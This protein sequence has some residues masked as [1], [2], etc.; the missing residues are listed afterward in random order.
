M[1][2][3]HEDCT[4]QNFSAVTGHIPLSQG[5][6]EALWSM[7]CKGGDHLNDGEKELLFHLLMEY[8]DVFAFNSGQIGRTSI[9]KHRIDTGNTPPVHL[10]PR[11]IHQAR[12]E[13]MA[14]LVKDMLEQG[15]IQ[16][17]DCPWS[18]PV[19]LVK[20]KNRSVRFCVDYRKVNSENAYPLPRVDDT[21]DTLAGSRLFTTLDLASGYWQ[22]EVAEDQPKTAFTTPEGLFQFRVM[23]F[24]LCNAP[25]T[26][27]RLMDRVLSELKWSSCLVYLDGIIIVGTSFSDH[28]RNLAGVL[29]RLR[30]AELKLKPSKCKWCQKSVT[31]LGHIVSEESIAVDPSKTAVV[32]HREKMRGI[33]LESLHDISENHTQITR[34][35]F[36]M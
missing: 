17:S 2:Q 19:V 32:A 23:P 10:L 3:L 34:V 8:A 6:K 11:R 31:F 5:D 25:A 33:I 12:R 21:L 18:S 26:F 36:S 27:Q 30:E 14:K 35:R 7:V 13:E 9:L 24:G 1:S 20:K 4:T 29:Q 22:V 15:A 28:L 16:Q